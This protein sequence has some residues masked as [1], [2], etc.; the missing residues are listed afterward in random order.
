MLTPRVPWPATDGGRV[1]MARL[2]ESL[3]RA[4]AEVEVL[5]LNPRKHRVTSPV[6]P[7][8]LQAIDINTWKVLAPALAFAK[9]D[10]PYVVRRFE[11]AEFRKALRLT[12]TRFRPEVV[13][14][15]SPFLLPYA[16]DVRAGSSARVV[17]RSLNVEFRIWESLGRSELTLLRR[18]VSRRLATSLRAFETRTLGVPDAI[19]PISIADRDDYQR[20][21]CTRPMHVAPCAVA[22]GG[23]ASFAPE[24]GTVAFIGSLDF[25]PNQ[26]AVRW[27]LEEL[28]PRVSAEVAGARLSIAGSAP[29]RWLRERPL[30]AGVELLGFVDDA[31]SFMRTRSVMIAP[32]FAGGGMRIKVLEAMALGCTVVAT[33]LGA[34][35]IDVEN[36]RD[37]MLAEDLES[38]AASVVRLLRDRELA[39][40]IGRA[41]RATVT[42]RY[43]GERI[44]RGLLA[45]YAS[46]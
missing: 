13:Q 16:D 20:L 33:A 44:A 15:E 12:L 43:D 34:G 10:A 35:G 29:P 39:Q 18:F 38:F 4:G 23:T 19:V 17:L 46:L 3:M 45:F 27:I 26:E 5:S 6:A 37:L 2:A 24:P 1:A 14:I 11:S 36:G 41:A 21:G 32:L 31:E 25:R 30:P 8:P 28:W 9:S 42:E 40:R 22:L 7:V